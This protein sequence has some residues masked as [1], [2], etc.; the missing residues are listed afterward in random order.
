MKVLTDHFVGLI[1][2]CPQCNAMLGYKAEDLYEGKYIYCARCKCKI[3]VPL[4]DISS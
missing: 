2:F 1:T 4:R 3:E